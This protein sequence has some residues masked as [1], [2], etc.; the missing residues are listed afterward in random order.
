MTQAPGWFEEALAQEPERGTAVVDGCTLETMAWGK[1][2]DPGLLLLHGNGAHV[3]WWRPF[4]PFFAEGT[5]VGAFSWSGMGGSERRTHYDFD[6]H[7]REIWAASEA[8]GLF[9]HQARPWIV[10]HSFGAIPAL[11]AVSG[12]GGDRFGGLVIVDSGYRPNP[13]V[14]PFEDRPQWTNPGYATLAEGAVR[15]RLRPEQPCP[16][17][18]MLDFIAAHSLDLRADGRWH[19]SFDPAAD[20]MRGLASGEDVAAA[21]R[22]ARCPLAYVWGEHSA[23]MTP[24]M[25]AMNRDIAAPGTPFVEIPGAAHHLMLDQPVAFIAAIRALVPA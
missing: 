2:G 8:M 11:F 13:A 15:F 23:L 5:R 6:L 4:A 7:R 19:W 12:E 18:W 3:H 1:A 20:R 14:S 22:G 10:A 17:D 16:N 24:D 25:M 9:D 21:I